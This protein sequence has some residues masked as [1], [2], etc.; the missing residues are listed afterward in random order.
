MKTYE[1]IKEVFVRK[2]SQDYAW[3]LGGSIVMATSAVLI[4]ILIGNVYGPAKLG[5]LNQALALYS[6]F[7]LL[8]TFGMQNSVLKYT[9]ETDDAN[10]I[11]QVISSALLIVMSVSLPMTLMTILVLNYLLPI[12]NSLSQ[13]AT[14]LLVGLPLFSLNKVIFGV[15]SGRREFKACSLGQTARWALILFYIGVAAL[16]RCTLSKIVIIFPITEAL[17]AFVLI[18]YI[19]KRWLK[20]FQLSKASLQQQMRFGFKSF[21]TGV[22]TDLNQKLDILIIG[23]FLSNYDVGIYSLASSIVKGLLII[24]AALQQNFNPV[25]SRLWIQNDIALIKTYIR[26]LFLVMLVTMGFIVVIFSIGYPVLV[27][28]IMKPQSYLASLPIFYILIVGVTAASFFVWTTGILSMTEHPGSVTVMKSIDLMF[29][30]ILTVSL[31]KTLG[32]YGAAIA[33]TTVYLFMIGVREY[34]IQKRTGLSIFA[35]FIRNTA[36]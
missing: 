8:T 11:D 19:K 29:N 23:Y 10:E 2:F 27:Y 24:P 20:S 6:V 9:A 25:V 28:F 15:L 36:Y 4:N 1:V 17:L 3:I 7:S 26:K 13:C 5:I 16:S 22:I 32:I 35:I 31:V 18:I 12:S 33:N 21:L 14:Y 30:L 34:I